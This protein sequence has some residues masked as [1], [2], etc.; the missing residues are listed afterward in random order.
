MLNHIPV[1]EYIGTVYR[2]CDLNVAIDLVGHPFI[3]S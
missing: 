3:F 1:V 2:K